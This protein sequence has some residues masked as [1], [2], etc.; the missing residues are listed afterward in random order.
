MLERCKHDMLRG[1]CSFCRGPSEEAEPLKGHKLTAWLA[2]F[3]RAAGAPSPSA[4]IQDSPL[5][6][7]SPEPGASFPSRAIPAVS[8]RRQ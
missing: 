5:N 3:A 1:S 2:G 6:H 8:R 4:P 7:E